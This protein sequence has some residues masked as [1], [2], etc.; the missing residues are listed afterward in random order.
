QIHIARTKPCANAAGSAQSAMRAAH[1]NTATAAR[2]AMRATA[3]FTLDAIPARSA[4]TPSNTAVVSG[5]TVKPRPSPNNARPG[6]TCVAYAPPGWVR[7]SSAAPAAAVNDPNVIGQ[8]CPT[9]EPSL[10]LIG[11]ST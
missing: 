1:G 8:R 2:P 10:P 7:V 5:A 9:F 6:R 3:L 11:D 4:G